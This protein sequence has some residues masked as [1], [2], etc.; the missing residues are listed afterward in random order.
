MVSIDDQQVSEG[1]DDTNNVDVG[2][3]R[4]HIEDESWF[5]AHEFNYSN[6]NEKK[7][8]HGNRVIR[9][10]NGNNKWVD[11]EVQ[12]YVYTL[13]DLIPLLKCLNDKHKKKKKWYHHTYQ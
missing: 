6:D 10:V 12:Y 1:D 3:M 11:K 8:D 4:Q 9:V 13:H 2:Y 5:L 7:A